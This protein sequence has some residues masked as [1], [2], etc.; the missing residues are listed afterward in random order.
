[1]AKALRAAYLVFAVIANPRMRDAA[2]ANVN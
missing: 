1:M 2:I